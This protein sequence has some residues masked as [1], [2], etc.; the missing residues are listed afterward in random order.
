MDHVPSFNPPTPYHERSYAFLSSRQT[1]TPG[2]C[3]ETTCHSLSV[4]CEVRISRKPYPWQLDCTEA[5]ILAIDCIVLAG[6][7]FGKTLPFTIPSL[8]H[9]NKITIVISP[10]NAL[11]EDQV[12]APFSRGRPKAAVVNHE[13]FDKELYEEL[14]NMNYQVIFTSP[15]MVFKRTPSVLKLTLGLTSDP[16]L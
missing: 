7:G 2:Y 9:P 11:E 4:I 6:T 16:L 14:K 5:L 1:N 12:C 13:T 3:S 8:L 15:E 10:L